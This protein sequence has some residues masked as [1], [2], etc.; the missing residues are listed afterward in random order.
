MD[1]FMNFPMDKIKISKN[2]MENAFFKVRFKDG[3][4]VSI[5]DKKN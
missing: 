5:F 3:D 1:F 4:I 2:T